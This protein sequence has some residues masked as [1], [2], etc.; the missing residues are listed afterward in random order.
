LLTF[1]KQ[2]NSTLLCIE[3]L[4]SSLEIQ[5]SI[6]FVLGDNYFS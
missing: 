5:F 2:P 6:S 3:P 1:G 4:I